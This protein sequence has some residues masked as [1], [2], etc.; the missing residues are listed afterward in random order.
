MGLV[1][2]SNGDTRLIFHLSF[3]FGSPDQI[4]KKSYN[5][6]TPD[7]YCK[8]KYRDLDAAVRQS[9]EILAQQEDT[10]I[11]YYSK[12]DLRSAFRLV[13]GKPEQFRWLLMRVQ[14]PD[15]GRYYFFADKNLPFGAS[16]SCHLFM[17]I[18]NCLRHIME[19]W[20]GRKNHCNNYLDDFLFS[21]PDEQE[22]NQLVRTFLSVCQ[23]LGVPVAEDKTEWTTP[24][25]Q[26]LGILLDGINHMLIVPEDKR[27]KALNLV[28]AMSEKKKATI[29]EIQ[30]LTGNLNFLGKAIVPGCAYTRLM[31]NKLK[32]TNKVGNTL[33][34]YYHVS[35]SQDFRDDCAMWLLF[36]Q[37]ALSR[38]LCRPFLDLELE[39]SSSR[40]D[41]YSDTSQAENLGFAVVFGEEYVYGQWEKGYIKRYQPS[42]VY[43]ELY[44]LCVGIFTWSHKLKNVRISI[45]CDNT[46]VRDMLN[47]TSTGCRNC[48]HL[49][50][51]I[52]LDNLISNRKI[53]V[54]YV[55][56]KQNG[57]AD[58]LSR[59]EFK[60]FF[61]ISPNFK[62]P[63]RQQKI[64]AGL[65]P[66]S[67]I[68]I[69]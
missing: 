22:C 45:Y 23:H 20:S 2:K 30:I 46:S 16:I 7:H 41:K 64:P 50:R 40:L 57:R 47:V 55:K 67:K 29:K 62:L 35:V 17:E 54:I 4:D 63:G 11:I 3:D 53:S 27:L 43:C 19:K 18:S 36:L 66:A 15:D 42:I 34:Q 65:W 32:T 13:P 26:F 24:R 28:S 1:P 39:S 31:Y 6:H 48:M 8:V 25:I 49:I 61:D 58:A 59:L 38:I 37:H 21:S 52:L 51:L 12:A 5:Y 60:Q 68:W 33:K 9:L 10:T 44:A 56:S 14:N 69:N